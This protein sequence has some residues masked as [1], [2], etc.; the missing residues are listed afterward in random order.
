M[1]KACEPPET[2]VISNVD[3]PAG[4]VELKGAVKT[5]FA[6]ATKCISQ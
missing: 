4:K 3:V 5:V 1:T 2:C 6:E